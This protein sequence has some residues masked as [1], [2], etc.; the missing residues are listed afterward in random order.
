[1]EAKPKQ[2]KP[3]IDKP[4]MEAIKAI[5]DHQVKTNQIVKK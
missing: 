5:K 3:K 2:D 1:M 4:T